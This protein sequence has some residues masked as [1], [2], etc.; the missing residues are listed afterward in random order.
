M[1][2]ERARQRTFLLAVLDA[3]LLTASFGCALAIRTQLDLPG[4]RKG[5]E[6]AP[7]EHIPVFLLSVP[8]FWVAASAAGLYR[9]D[10]VRLGPRSV[11]SA[12]IRTFA[13][14]TA[15]LGTA[16]FV[17]QAK[18]F[19]RGVFVLFLTLA[20]VA[21]VGVRVAMVRRSRRPSNARAGHRTAL[22]VGTG[23]AARDVRRKIED[24]PEYALRVLGHLAVPGEPHPPDG[25][26]AALGTIDA[27]RDIVD[28]EVV[29]EVVFA[30][31]RSHLLAC[32][33]YIQWCE[34]VGL[35]VHIRAD[36]V[37]TFFAKTI[38]TDLEG[39]PMLTVAP[40]PR[41]AMSLLVK[42]TI[43]LVGSA[44]GL[45]VSAPVLAAVSVLVKLSSPGPVLFRQQRVGLNGRQFTLLKFRS[46]YADAEQR[47]HE[48]ESRNEVSGPVFKMARDPR[49][50]P[51]GEFLRKTSLD[52][53]PQLWNV[54]RGDMSLVGPRPP[55]PEEVRRYE[56]WQRRRLSMKP[57]LTCLWQISGRSQI[58]FEE[59]M[60]LDLA[61]IDN[62]SLRLDAWILLRTV[63][64]VLSARGA[65]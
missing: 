10:L 56:R 24:H 5:F 7:G 4:F 20:S 34:E 16:I 32:D 48:L 26:D 33:E 49:V 9:G 45:L 53:L 31:P 18:G 44:A 52:E 14:L 65:H 46:M 23:D 21:V 19:S 29:D 2:S 1:F 64:A 58:P 40:T 51:V 54:L 57:G 22:I 8:L 38:A 13:Y 61:Y 25:G 37:R 3:V 12:G 62:W 59:W 43:D 6:A 11:V 50:T 30:V 15:V 39:T 55:I 42:R 28:R 60:R 36:F 27:L 47:R 63:P 35:T 41:D 17:F